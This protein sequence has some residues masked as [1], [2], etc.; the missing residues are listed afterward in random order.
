MSWDLYPNNLKTWEFGKEGPQNFC[1]ERAAIALGQDASENGNYGV[2][3]TQPKTNSS[4][5]LGISVVAAFPLDI[6]V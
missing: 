1:S 6:N 4:S 2:N 3:P 5:C